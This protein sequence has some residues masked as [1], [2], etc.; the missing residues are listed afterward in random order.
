MIEGVNMIP[1]GMNK[2][3]NAA[4]YSPKYY[5]NSNGIDIV[6]SKELDFGSLTTIKGNSLACRILQV[7][8][9]DTNIITTYDTKNT[10]A[11]TSTINYTSSEIGLFTESSFDVIGCIVASDYDVIFAK[12]A[13]YN[14]IFKL[15]ENALSL[16]YIRNN[17][18][19]SFGS[20]INGLFNKENENVGKI[21]W[22]DGEN[23]V[24]TLN[25]LDKNI[26]DQPIKTIYV[27]PEITYKSAPKVTGWSY[28]GLHTSG[29]IQYAYNLIKENGSQTRL[30]PL[31]EMYSLKKANKGENVNKRVYMVNDISIS[32]IDTEYDVI[33]VYSLKYNSILGDPIVS[34]I[35]EYSIKD[36]GTNDLT[37]SDDGRDIGKL[38]IDAFISI[39]GLPIICKSI[40]SKDSRLF[41]G[42]FKSSDFDI[43][44]DTRAYSF[45]SSGLLGVRV[46]ID[47]KSS[48][49]NM[50]YYTQ[51]P[52]FSGIDDFFKSIPKDFDCINTDPDEYNMN[53]NTAPGGSGLN[54]SY[55]FIDTGIKPHNDPDAILFKQG[56][57]YRLGIEFY[58]QFGQPS[59]PKWIADFKTPNDFNKTIK[60]LRVTLRPSALQYLKDHNVCG[61]RLLRAVRRDYDKTVICQGILQPTLYQEIQRID[62][63]YNKVD[64]NGKYSKQNVKFPSTILRQ[65]QP[66]RTKVLNG[67][68]TST[69]LCPIKQIANLNSIVSPDEPYGEFYYST[70]QRNRNVWINSELI[71]FHSPEIIFNDELRI[72]TGAQVRFI[73]SRVVS[74]EGVTGKLYRF[75][76]DSIVLSVTN[77]D[78]LSIYKAADAVYNDD[79]LQKW[80]IFSP[81]PN[82]EGNQLL[83]FYRKLDENMTEYANPDESISTFDILGTPEKLDQSLEPVKYNGNNDYSFRNNFVFTE[84]DDKHGV[85]KSVVIVSMDTYGSDS[86]LMQLG[87]KAS[88]TLTPQTLENVAGVAGLSNGVPIVD[89]TTNV[90]NQYGGNTYEDKKRT[91]YTH[92]GEY[93]D[94]AYD[95]I[96]TKKYGDTYV[97]N[98]K[99]IRVGR[100]KTDDVFFKHNR[101]RFDEVVEV[102]LETTID[103]KSRSDESHEESVSA[104]QYEMDEYHQYNDVYSRQSSIFNRIDTPFTFKEVKEFPA[105]IRA[106]SIKYP[107]ELIDSWTDILVNETKDLDSKYGE[108]TTLYNF[109]DHIYAFQERAVALMSINP[110]VAVSANDGSQIGLGTGKLLDDYNYLST[111]SGLKYMTAID[112][113]STGIYYIDTDNKSMN[114]I[115]QDGVTSLST[116]KGMHSFC[117]DRL[118]SSLSGIVVA[119]NLNDKV[120]F[121]VKCNRNFS[122]IYSEMAD[123]FTHFLP[124]IQDKYWGLSNNKMMSGYHNNELW[125]HDT[126]LYNDFYGVS[127]ESSISFISAPGSI[128]N[129]FNNVIS[130]IDIEG[131]AQG[132]QSVDMYIK[133]ENEYQQTAK[134]KLVF[135]RNMNKKYRNWFMQ[136]PRDALNPLRRMRGRWIKVTLYFDNKGNYVSLKDTVITH[137]K[138]R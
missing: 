122:L 24:A 2:D 116:T 17:N 125:L 117:S 74:N 73:G 81:G 71:Q 45:K 49:N 51:A 14:A 83:H 135:N 13:N 1:M 105:S 62:S 119:D 78:G 34:I 118:G 123:A 61:W 53:L 67:D 113:T 42:N 25:I 29:K 134:T 28:G 64:S 124:I 66:T 59:R 27:C 107:N 132:L 40:S 103:L 4:K 121:I 43:D 101:L 47:D 97:Q 120:N 65:L 57:T 22:T 50:S 104:F 102:I 106:T 86:Y 5:F 58:N 31:S 70:N 127:Y 92:I 133:A 138:I 60:S 3:V 39:G 100:D 54:L 128:D 126:G 76:S 52:N 72:P 75:D 20:Y 32:N 9:T 11:V 94:I 98:F 6:Q 109:N 8:A 79:Y 131:M 85:D 84:I 55:R 91:E 56:E 112:N 33:R 99:F 110:R 12:G 37:F 63:S 41:I 137:N 89:I 46:S 87:N 77:T 26:I 136:I 93:S 18:Q 38:S 48:G 36:I 10:N 114:K 69:D 80:G 95:Y 129:V 88:S 16:L 96:I 111:V 35:K 44:I 82:Q 23:N 108:I 7:R 130:C 68:G 19:L 15:N 115:T 21:Y 90:P 30:S